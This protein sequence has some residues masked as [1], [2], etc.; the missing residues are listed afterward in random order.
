[1]ATVH[2]LGFMREGDVERNYWASWTARDILETQP[3]PRRHPIT[4]PKPK[5]SKPTLEPPL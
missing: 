1:M 3:E 4:S 5:N 2:E